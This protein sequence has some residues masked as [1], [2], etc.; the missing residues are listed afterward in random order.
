MC[1]QKSLFLYMKVPLDSTAIYLGFRDKHLFIIFALLI[2]LSL[3]PWKHSL[4]L[5]IAA[6]PQ[7]ISLSTE[8]ASCRAKEK[9]IP[10]EE[11][12]ANN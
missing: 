12:N 5:A 10:R 7:L 4:P 6:V 3:Q 2:I 1:I 11:P 9:L 8:Y